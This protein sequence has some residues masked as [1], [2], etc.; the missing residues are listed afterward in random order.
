MAQN[1][2][3]KWE[4]NRNVWERERKKKKWNEMKGAENDEQNKGKEWI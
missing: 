4:Y 1:L 2:M 3:H